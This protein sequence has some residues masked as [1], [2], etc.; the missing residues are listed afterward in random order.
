MAL[1]CGQSSLALR[2]DL[3]NQ[4]IARANLSA[5][6][7][8]T[9]VVEVCKHVLTKVWNL[10]GNLLSTKLGIT[11]INLV[12]GNVNGGQEVFLNNTL[13]DDNTVLVVVAFPWHGG[14]AP[15]DL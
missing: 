4:N 10:A 1:F 9:V 12:A 8:D 13:G 11:S 15:P 2:S 7:D 5:D 14:T 3:T 6:A